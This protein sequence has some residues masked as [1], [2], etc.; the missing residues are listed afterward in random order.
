MLLKNTN[1]F[2]TYCQVYFIGYLL[3]RCTILY[4]VMDGGY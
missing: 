2:V 4:N 3:L 1:V